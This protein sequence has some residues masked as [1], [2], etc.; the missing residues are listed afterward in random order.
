MGKKYPKD[1][2]T[3]SRWIQH[4]SFK[5][6]NP[7][8]YA[9]NKAFQRLFSLFYGTS[10]TDLT[11]EK[12]F[13]NNDAAKDRMRLTIA[14]SDGI[15]EGKNG[16]FK[17]DD[18]VYYFDETGLMVLGPCYDTIGNYYFFSYDTGEMIEEIQKR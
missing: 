16:F 14:T 18:K 2:T 17:I 8:K 5:G 1:I 3:A 11:E 9:F 10:I 15:I 13:L 4:G 6:Y 7:I 12:Y